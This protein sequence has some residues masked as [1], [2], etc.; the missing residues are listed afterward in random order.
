MFS[1]VVK[2]VASENKLPLGNGVYVCAC[3][4]VCLHVCTCVCVC[5]RA[6]CVCLRVCLCVCAR[7]PMVRQYSRCTSSYFNEMG[8][9][10]RNSW[11]VL[12]Y[13]FFVLSIHW[14]GEGEEGDSLGTE[15]KGVPVCTV[16]VH[17]A[18]S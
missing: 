8:N 6:M 18:C 17:R 13:S 4:C 10:L 16:C 14:H 5:M 1:G 11:L 9:N 12:T 2:V 15:S 3:V 7:G